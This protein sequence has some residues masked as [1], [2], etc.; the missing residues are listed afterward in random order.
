[1]MWKEDQATQEAAVRALANMAAPAGI[2][3]ESA[4]SLLQ[5][6]KAEEG[7]EPEETGDNSSS[8][9]AQT[10]SKAGGDGEVP[11]LKLKLKLGTTRSEEFELAGRF[12][13]S[14]VAPEDYEEEE[15]L[16]PGLSLEES[17]FLQTV[18]AAELSAN[19]EEE[20]VEGEE[21]EDGGAGADGGEGEGNQEQDNDS[22]S[23]SDAETTCSSAPSA[24]S[25]SE[26]VQLDVAGLAIAAADEARARATTAA[27]AAR[28]ERSTTFG[29]LNND[30]SW[31]GTAEG[32]QMMLSYNQSALDRIH[33][34]VIESAVFTDLFNPTLP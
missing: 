16:Q 1:M 9:V 14:F 31:W 13:S 27:T 2:I 4:E 22:D 19:Q 28:K 3:S 20:A 30:P 10:G 18:S 5:R 34:K 11:E 23:N 21:E 15:Q 8:E 25:S 29:A 17:L 7:N 26:S 33:L 12:G 24:V 6:Q 32:A